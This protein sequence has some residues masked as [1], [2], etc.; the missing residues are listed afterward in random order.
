MMCLDVDVA[1]RHEASFS[2]QSDVTSPVPGVAR[3]GGRAAVDKQSEGRI[4]ACSADRCYRCAVA[5]PVN[6]RFNVFITSVSRANK[7]FAIRLD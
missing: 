7:N 6:I 3:S 5:A 2:H 1:C 4:T